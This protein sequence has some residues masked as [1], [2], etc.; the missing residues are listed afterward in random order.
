MKPTAMEIAAAV[1]QLGA[2][3]FF[4]SDPSA[5]EAVMEVLERMVGTSEQ[6]EWLVRTMIDEVGE[7]KGP[8]ELRGVFCTR[9]RPLDGIEAHCGAG[10]FSAEAIESRAAIEAAELRKLPVPSLALLRANDDN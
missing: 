10:R 1:A 3:L 5:R 6:L 9:F 4:P 2:L 8:K 7:W